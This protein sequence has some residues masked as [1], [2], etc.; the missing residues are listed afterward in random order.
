MLNCGRVKDLISAY[1][2]KELEPDV[3]LEV[4]RHLRFCSDCYETEQSTKKLF[5]LA[6]RLEEEHPSAL[7]TQTVMD[8]IRSESA[9]ETV[10]V[11]RNFKSAW[12]WVVPATAVAAALLLILSGKLD[13]LSNPTTLGDS[14]AMMIKPADSMDSPQISELNQPPVEFVLDS[15]NYSRL[16]DASYPAPSSDGSPDG[17]YLTP[18]QSSS[19]NGNPI[20][21]MPTVQNSTS[22]YQTREAY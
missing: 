4:E 1:L 3:Q 21:V 22:E 9:R 8:E 19:Q 10:P 11:R 17:I 18:A 7:F 16:I 15:W 5:S 6:S 20:Y 14:T 2:E 13:W 12:T